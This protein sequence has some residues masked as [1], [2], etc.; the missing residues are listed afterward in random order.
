MNE[1]GHLFTTE[2]DIKQNSVNLISS[3]ALFCNT[4]EVVLSSAHADFLLTALVFDDEI[5]IYHQDQLSG[6]YKTKG[7]KIL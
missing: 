5:M 7:V 4:R 6:S 2:Y 1:K 3:Y